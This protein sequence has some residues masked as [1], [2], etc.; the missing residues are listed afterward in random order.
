MVQRRTLS[1]RA[2]IAA[3]LIGT[4][5]SG[6]AHQPA[7]VREKPVADPQGAILFVSMSDGSIIQQTV[8]LDADFCMKSVRAPE[9]TCFK[10]GPAIHDADGIVVGH[11][12][13]RS[14]INLYA[15]RTTSM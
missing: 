6:C 2:S 15:A 12:M 4:L 9:T 1:I 7:E 11:R 14:E 3:A 5:F 8:P 10:Q 13:I